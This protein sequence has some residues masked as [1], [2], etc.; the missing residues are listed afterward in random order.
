MLLWTLLAATD[1]VDPK[2][3]DEAWYADPSELAPGWQL[4]F[5]EGDVIVE[6]FG[7]RMLGLDDR[8]LIEK[9]E[10]GPRVLALVPAQAEILDATDARV[11]GRYAT[12]VW[13]LWSG[14]LE[15][16]DFGEEVG[17]VAVDGLDVRAWIGG[18]G[19][20]A[21]RLGEGHA[22]VVS[23]FTPADHAALDGHRLAWTEGPTLHVQ[24]RWA[25]DW[26]MNLGVDINALEPV[27]GGWLV[28]GG[29]RPKRVTSWGS[30]QQ[31]DSR[32]QR[33]SVRLR[34]GPTRQK[35]HQ[36]GG[37][38]VV[39]DPS[40]VRVWHT[41]DEPFTLP[42][43]SL[44]GSTER[45]FYVR[46]GGELLFLAAPDDH[47]AVE[48][49]PTVW[50]NPRFLPLDDGRAVLVEAGHVRV[51]DGEETVFEGD[52]SLHAPEDAWFLGDG[53]LVLRNARAVSIL[54]E[55]EEL[56]YRRGVDVEIS[57]DGRWLAEL[58]GTEVQG[59]R[60]GRPGSLRVLGGAGHL[61]SD[62][63]GLV[64]DRERH[65][66]WGSWRAVEPEP[67]AEPERA[68]REERAERQLYTF[69]EGWLVL[70]S[71]GRVVGEDPNRVAIIRDGRTLRSAFT[72]D[73]IAFATG[74]HPI[75]VSTE[76]E[77]AS[78][79]WAGA[80]A[81]AVLFSWRRRGRPARS[82]R[83]C[84]GSRRRPRWTR[85]GAGPG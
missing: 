16:Y 38:A 75:E 35:V 34:A 41:S 43:G 67:A 84:R 45:G 26:T 13:V 42:P 62:G 83:R 18:R 14:D 21:W 78:P 33:F 2:G 48:I 72:D 85:R 64:L 39:F 37:L 58:V 15:H 53:A 31:L 5:R 6:D 11:V 40:A 80:F 82:S 4:G 1:A 70:G 17:P 30:R 51:L 19:I 32:P 73:P 23:E 44:L 47:I 59:R 9:T 20:A 79:W 25:P 71:D 81:L 7:G 54:T 10:A 56:F 76:D 66:R 50:S 49:I 36:A 12:G 60:V 74:A 24:R 69:D 22:T 3:D 61:Q 63:D 65:L 27:D 55:E 57:R 52:T 46:W 29:R 68:E 77:A 8:W 28:W